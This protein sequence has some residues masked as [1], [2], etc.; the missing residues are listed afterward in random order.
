MQKIKSISEY[1]F[2]IFK[3][4]LFK[5]KIFYFKSNFYNKKIS[6][7][8]PSKFNYKP[9]LHI[10]NSLTSFNKKKIKIENYSLNSLWKLSSKNK[11]EF[12]NLHNFLWLTFL[13]IKT[14]KA[15]AQTI[16]ENW[17]DNNNDFNEE[18]WK[19]D[20]LSKRLIAWISNANL[21]LDESG[22]KYKEKFILSIT[23]QANHLS[24]NIVSLEDDENKLTCCSSLILVGLVFKNHYKHYKSGLSIL[25]KL[26]K[27]NFDNSGFPKSRN[28]EE[29]MACL[30][31]LILI[32]EWIKESQNPIPDYLEE[33]IYHCGKSYSFLSKNLNEL[34]L[35]NGSSEIKNEEFEKYLNYFNYNFNDNSKENNGYVIFKNKKIVLIM[36]VGN[37]PDFKYSKKYQSGCLSFEINSNGEK[38]ICNLGFDINKNNKIK[39]L[40]RTTAAHSTLYLNNHSS[41]IFRTSDPFRIH[42]ENMLRKGLKITKKKIVSEKDFENIIASHNGYQN[43]YGYIH[44]R[45]IKFIKKEKIFLGIDNLIKNKKASNISYGIRFHIYPG[46]K[47][48]KTQNSQSILLSLKNGEGWKFSCYNKEVL[49]EKGIYLGNKNKIIENENIYILGMTNGEN[50]IIEWSFEKIS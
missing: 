8:L 16:I 50:Q 37:S 35:F 9:S 30:K 12:Q 45:S 18:T 33:I 36:D 34:P 38:L 24:M 4:F 1:F 40:S 7:N 15:P 25:Q 32:K 31:Y 29:L 43:R 28:P 41:C 21:T 19:L 5:L 3:F 17:I 13:D 2:L 14:N 39:L 26:I 20:I 46:I 49:I 23:K 42:Q 27:N 6:N 48:V 47:I 44:E 22:L 10:I 11:L